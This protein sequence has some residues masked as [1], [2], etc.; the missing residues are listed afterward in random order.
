MRGLSLLV[1]GLA[2][3]FAYGQVKTDKYDFPTQEIKDVLI[4]NSTGNVNIAPSSDANSYVIV[5][6]IKW[7]PRCSASVELNDGHLRAEINDAAWILD[8]ECRV[9]LVVS[10]PKKIPLQVRAGT[11]DVQ[12][13]ASRGDID[14]KVGSGL[15]SVKGEMAKLNAMAGSGDVKVDGVVKSG[16][17]QTGS[18]DIEMTYQEAPLDGQLK[19]QTGSGDVEVYLPETAKVKSLISTGNGTV[20][21]EFAAAA[22]GD[23]INVS[24][25]SESGDIQIRKK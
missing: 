17:I 20:V 8:H 3:P 16:S 4:H 24:A 25:S 2:V 22:E 14:V 6:K 1:L 10:L 9:D 7:G 15:I 18:G 12:I 5:N 11:G 23:R 19:V 21:N 13:L